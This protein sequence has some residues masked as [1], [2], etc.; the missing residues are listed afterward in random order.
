[1]P[2]GEG[3]LQV[4]GIVVAITIAGGCDH[5]RR[6]AVAA[7][8]SRQAKARCRD[9]ITREAST[10]VEQ[11]RAG[12][13]GPAIKWIGE[14]HVA[15]SQRA[16]PFSSQKRAGEVGALIQGD[17]PHH[18]RIGGV[19]VRNCGVGRRKKT[20]VDGT[21]KERLSGDRREVRSRR[22]R[23]TGRWKRGVDA[24]AVVAL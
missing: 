5:R 22:F 13:V 1:M 8:V 4:A 3:Q 7:D 23:S 9:W 11:P 6:L 10:E 17:K 12:K 20:R 16:A 18:G 24:R 2:V 21:L 15:A 19:K 14:S